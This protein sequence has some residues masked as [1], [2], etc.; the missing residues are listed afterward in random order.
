MKAK[1]VLEKLNINEINVGAC[2]GPDDWYKDPEAKEAVS[3]NPATG[4]SIASVLQATEKTY[5]QVLEA[6]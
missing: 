6:A 2:A 4:E 1:A 3:I 5:E